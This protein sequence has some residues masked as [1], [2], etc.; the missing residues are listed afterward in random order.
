ML[1]SVFFSS[2]LGALSLNAQYDQKKMTIVLL[3][4]EI[5]ENQENQERRNK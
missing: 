1:L 3:K 2:K 4:S 5:K